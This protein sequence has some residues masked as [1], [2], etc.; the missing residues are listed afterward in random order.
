MESFKAYFGLYLLKNI[1]KFNS[2]VMKLNI[3]R[4]YF[5]CLVAPKD[6][7]LYNWLIDQSLLQ[8]KTLLESRD[9]YRK[10]KYNLPRTGVYPTKN[11]DS[12]SSYVRSVSFGRVGKRLWKLQREGWCSRIYAITGQFQAPCLQ[13]IRIC[14]WLTAT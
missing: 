13:W 7:Y 12:K 8:W 10:T 11:P 5:R 2:I 6:K 3:V 14:S 1:F 9:T 4:T